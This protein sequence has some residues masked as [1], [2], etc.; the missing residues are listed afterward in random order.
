MCQTCH[1]DLDA[2]SSAPLDLKRFKRFLPY[3]L[4]YLIVTT[5]GFIYSHV[6]AHHSG[7]SLP[8]PPPHLVL[9]HT[10]LSADELATKLAQVGVPKEAVLGEPYTVS[11]GWTLFHY[12]ALY[13]VMFSA[14]VILI[15]AFK[16]V[17]KFGTE[18]PNIRIS[19]KPGG[20]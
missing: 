17:F 14:F 18:P 7:T 15:W 1:T 19:C 5:A 9:L 3:F 13:A 20:I 12:F 8:Q 16:R 10:S 4:S 11:L 6:M 2:P